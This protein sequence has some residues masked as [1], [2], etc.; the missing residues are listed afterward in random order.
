MRG[1]VLPFRHR[2]RAFAS[3]SPGM[4]MLTWDT[5]DMAL[6][7]PEMLPDTLEAWRVRGMAAGHS[8]RTI[9][10]RRGTVRRLVL[11]GL[12]PMGASEGELEAWLANLTDT[13]TGEPVKRSSLATYRAHLRA[14]Y[15][16]LAESGR[17]EDDPSLTLPSARAPRGVPRPVSPADV[18]AIL[19]ACADPRARQTA[20]YVTLAAF[21]GMRVHEIAK[22]R[23]EDFMGGEIAV[24]GKGGVVST[25]PL[26]PVIAR[27]AEEMP[28]A[29]W[30]FPTDSASGHVHRCSVSSAISRAMRRAGVVGTPHALR[31]FYCTQVLRSTGGDL[32]KT[33]RLARHASPATT[34]IYTQVLDDEL[35]HAASMIPGAA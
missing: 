27:L 17:R 35:L 2:A 13:R 33:Q 18:T 31:H 12:D 30:W 20:A 26:V 32:R 25:L 11:D 24:T 7:L 8:P 16:W 34:A 15:G 3:G 5:G 14:W 1:T 6:P 4:G 9:A 21:A 22:V 29:G 23:G 28:R 19:A 10:A